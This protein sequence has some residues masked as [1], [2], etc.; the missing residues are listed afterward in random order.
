MIF[1]LRYNTTIKLFVYLILCLLVYL[2]I[3]YDILIADF[4]K[5]IIS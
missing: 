2:F 1:N 5:T 4:K 3:I